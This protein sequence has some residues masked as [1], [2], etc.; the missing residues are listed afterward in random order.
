MSI[1]RIL[2]LR[3]K[4]KQF[5]G[6]LLVDMLAG[7]NL[8]ELLQR[9]IRSRVVHV[10]LLYLRNMTFQRL[11]DAAI[12]NPPSASIVNGSRYSIH[13]PSSPILY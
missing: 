9:P 12:R 8:N 11:N 10:P 7:L 1:L 5:P 6:C 2:Q 13:V 4:A 3:N